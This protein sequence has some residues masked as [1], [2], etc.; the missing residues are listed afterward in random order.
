M[1][2]SSGRTDHAR[3]KKYKREGKS[4]RQLITVIFLVGTRNR[5]GR[6]RFFSSNFDAHSVRTHFSNA[7][8]TQLTDTRFGLKSL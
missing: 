2:K 4:Y 8:R 6:N 1:P 7:Y 5:D 3:I